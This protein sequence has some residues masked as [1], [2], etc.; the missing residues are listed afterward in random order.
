MKNLLVLVL[1]LLFVLAFGVISM[2]CDEGDDTFACEHKNPYTPEI[3]QCFEFTAGTSK[4]QATEWC[5]NLTIGVPV[6]DPVLISSACDEAKYDPAGY[7]DCDMNDEDPEG[8][9]PIRSQDYEGI[10]KGFMIAVVSPDL[11]DPE[12][13][14]NTGETFSAAWGCNA[15]GGEFVCTAN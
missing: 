13:D 14:C 3:A 10:V 1:S 11:S 6:K 12:M 9:C 7:C 4:A 2:A 8:G 5:E 15:W